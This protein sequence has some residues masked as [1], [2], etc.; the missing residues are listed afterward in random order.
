M[1]V[2][3]E[4][5]ILVGVATFALCAVASPGEA[6]QAPGQARPVVGAPAA[7]QEGYSYKPEGRRDPFVSLVNRA[8]DP[9]QARKKPE[10]MRGFLFD[11]VTLR[12]VMQGRGAGPIAL[13]QGPDNK[14]YLVHVGDQLYDAVV[15]AITPDSIVVVQEV[16]DPLSLTKQRERRKTLR[17]VEEVK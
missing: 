8:S 4:R 16:N 14:T 9:R 3:T 11:E 17:V 13:V 5:W 7:S 12:G 10:G 6:R 15:R 1:G 2:T